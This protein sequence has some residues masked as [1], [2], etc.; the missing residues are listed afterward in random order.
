MIE[1]DTTENLQQCSFKRLQE[2]HT[3]HKT[4]AALCKEKIE[5]VEAELL[6]R[7]GSEFAE[8]LAKSGRQ[9][10][11]I[12]DETNDGIKLTYSVKSKVEWDQDAMKAIAA[13]MPWNMVER[14]FKIEFAVPERTFKALTDQSLIDKLTEARTVKYSEPKVTFSK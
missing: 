6:S 5:A 12:T 7:V 8:Q 9:H 10:G 2:I 11:D 14:V 4:A 13:S 1:P 3:A